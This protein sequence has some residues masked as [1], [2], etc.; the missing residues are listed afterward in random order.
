MM[1]GAAGLAE[2]EPGACAEPQPG[3]V[4]IHRIGGGGLGQSQISR[5]FEHPPP[6]MLITTRC[7]CLL[8]S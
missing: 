3:S 5:E 7:H 8:I 6:P 1:S 2:P 4:K